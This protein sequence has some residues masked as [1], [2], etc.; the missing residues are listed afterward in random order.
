[1]S[2]FQLTTPVAF[3]IFTRP[4]TTARVFKEIARAKPPKLMVVADG[5][6][7]DRP[8]EAERCA[9]A[10]AII[11]Q[12]DWECE[13]LTNYADSNMGCKRRVSSGLDWVFATVE[14]AIILEDDCL[15][16]PTFFRFCQELL[17]Q[18]RDDERV[19][20]ISG[21][22]M[23]VKK[24]RIKWSYY[25]SKRPNCW[26]W[27]S[28][29]RAWKY[30][31]VELKLWPEIRDSGWLKDILINP[32]V[33]QKRTNI[34]QKT[35]KNQIDTW[36]YQWNFACWIQNGLSILPK[37]NLITNI[38]FRED[39]THTKGGT[40]PLLGTAIPMSFPLVHPPFVICDYQ[41]DMVYFKPSFKSI[42]LERFKYLK[43]Y[44]NQIINLSKEKGVV[45]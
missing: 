20:H 34:L 24:P 15:P 22:D 23:T 6:C 37:E 17:E 1:M 8:G 4:D 10:R 35:Y 39:A 41:T 13:V 32:L 45:K 44:T 42:I 27:A 30:Y 36:D 40:S 18:Y 11:E 9:A 19:M 3:L 5:P 12:V 2:N 28:W 31:D 16:H 26:G 38:G 14:E 7:P 33:V 25:Y 29:R 43:G 21:N